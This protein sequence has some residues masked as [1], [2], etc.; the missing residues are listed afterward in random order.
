MWT[1]WKDK[2]GIVDAVKWDYPTLAAREDIARALAQIDDAEHYL[3][4]LMTSTAEENAFY[5]E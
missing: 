2:R 3:D 5:E 1:Y 4:F